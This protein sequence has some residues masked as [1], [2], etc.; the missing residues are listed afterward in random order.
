MTK[1]EKNM[2][3][4][5]N[6]M[7]AFQQL[8]RKDK[9]KD[10]FSSLQKFGEKY[11]ITNHEKIKSILDNYAK[12]CI[13]LGYANNHAVDTYYVLN[14]MTWKVI[15]THEAILMNKPYFVDDIVEKTKSR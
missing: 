15:L 10:I 14:P 12:L 9:K 13:W 3:K 8:V 1:L 5:F 7:S 2:V 4:T 11:I 6:G